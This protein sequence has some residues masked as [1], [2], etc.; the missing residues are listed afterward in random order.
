MLDGIKQIA[1]FDMEDDFLEA[2]AAFR[3]ELFVLGRI[4]GEVLVSGVSRCVPYEHTTWRCDCPLLCPLPTEREVIRYENLRVKNGGLMPG[5][6]ASNRLYDAGPD[7]RG[8]TV[9][10][11]V[12][13]ERKLIA[14]GISERDQPLE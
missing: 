3:L 10:R 11:R 6:I 9:N 4:P 5:F 8:Q 1:A 13:G 7:R 12:A 14:S 2:D